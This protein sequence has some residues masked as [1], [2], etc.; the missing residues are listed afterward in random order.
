MNLLLKRQIRKYLSEEDLGNENVKGFIEAVKKSYGSYEDQIKMVVHATT[1]G[2]QEL[3]EANKALKEETARQ[4]ELLV[5]LNSVIS[6]LNQ[7]QISDS[8]KETGFTNQNALELI[9]VIKKQTETIKKSEVERQILLNN[10][11]ESNQEL[12]DYAHVVSHDL[13]SPLR[14]IDTLINWV[15]EDNREK[16]SNSTLSTFEMLLDKVEKMDNLITGVLEFSRIKRKTVVEEYIDLNSVVANV[17]SMMNTTQTQELVVTNRLPILKGEYYK[18]YQLFYNLIGNAVEAIPLNSGKVC[19]S[20]ENKT[21]GWIFRIKDNGPGI[22][23]EYRE[24]IFEAFK[25]ID[26]RDTSSGIGLSIVKKVVDY[27]G[28]EIW[29]DSDSENGTM[30]SFTLENCYEE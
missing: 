3:S 18:F 6:I 10:L 28:G 4:K 1:L 19:V 9:E 26:K 24:V 25:S 11:Q 30:F 21:K 12:E 20:V 16:F 22:P 17:F 8:I 5:R 27:Y 13:K 2:S 15:L 7:F 29:I 23:E 14:S